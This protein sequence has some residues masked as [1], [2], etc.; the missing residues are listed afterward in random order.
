MTEIPSQNIKDQIG[1]LKSQMVAKPTADVSAFIDKTPEQI[2]QWAESEPI[3]QVLSISKAAPF[4]VEKFK[5]ANE[6]LKGKGSQEI[7]LI[8]L[9]EAESG[10]CREITTEVVSQAREAFHAFVE[11]MLKDE[12]I[13]LL[14][15]EFNNFTIR[16][17]RK[18]EDHHYWNNMGLADKENGLRNEV[19]GAIDE[20]I[21]KVSKVLEEK[22][23]PTLVDSSKQFETSQD[24]Y[25]GLLLGLISDM[26]RGIFYQE[27][28]PDKVKAYKPREIAIGVIKKMHDGLIR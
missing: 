11:E 12:N 24:R 5:K 2:A 27:L 25:R 1:V 28:N 10:I 19:M 22:V 21:A 14:T 6:I 26:V 8:D 23:D 17:G 9:G 20:V 16:E 15:Y 13:N 3:A 18:L 7:T 4:E